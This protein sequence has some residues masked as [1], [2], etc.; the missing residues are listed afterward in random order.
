V[1][2]YLLD[3]GTLAPRKAD[4]HQPFREGASRALKSGF[5]TH[6]DGSAILRSHFSK[7]EIK[8]HIRLLGL[9]F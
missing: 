8:K 6:L 1:F 9:L 4:P 7:T 3:H 2:W 5:A